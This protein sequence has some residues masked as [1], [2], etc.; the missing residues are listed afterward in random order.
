MNLQLRSSLILVTLLLFACSSYNNSTPEPIPTDEALTC[1]RL[2]AASSGAPLCLG[3]AGSFL[4]QTPTGEQTTLR[5]GA[6]TLTFDATVHL[7]ISPAQFTVAVLEGTAVL[8]AGGQARII[9]PGTQSTVDVDSAD[10]TAIAPPTTLRPYSIN[11]IQ[12]APLR[13]LTREITLPQPAGAIRA[14]ATAP[15]PQPTAPGC[16]PRE[17]WIFLYTVQRGDTLGGIAAAHQTT[18]SELSAGNC[19]RDPNRII[20][21]TTLKVPEQTS[22]GT[23]SIA[24]LQPEQSEIE[25][26]GCVILRWGQPD[27]SVVYFQGEPVAREDAREACPETTTT[28][29][30]LVIEEDGAQ[31]GYTAT[32]RISG[33]TEEDHQPMSPP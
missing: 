22:T 6:L 14:E 28:Y 17:D 20:P 16:V 18:T 5:L 7:S 11:I 12:R 3:R 15:P 30:L 29:T 19:M 25:M 13:E 32:I 33:E 27:A 8:G 23:S 4:L 24:G 1:A 31:I 2:E 10:F 26:G 21:G 9:Q